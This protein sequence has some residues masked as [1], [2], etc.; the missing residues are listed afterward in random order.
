METPETTWAPKSWNCGLGKSQGYIAKTSDRES[1]R[2][3]Y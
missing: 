2:T 1:R 3:Q